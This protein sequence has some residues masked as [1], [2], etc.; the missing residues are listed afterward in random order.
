MYPDLM[1]RIFIFACTS[2]ALVAWMLIL[3]RGYG[4]LY[5]DDAYMFYRYAE[6]ARH[7]LGFSWNLDGVHTFG[8]TSL[9][10]ALV[11]LL[12][13]FLPLGPTQ[14]LLFASWITS[15][16]AIVCVSFA[17]IRN[18]RSNWLRDPALVTPVVALSLLSMKIF[19]IN[20]R[21]GMETMLAMALLA[22]CLH[23]VL[24]Q[25]RR[26][27]S[28]LTMGILVILTT[29]AR[30]EAALPVVLL[31]VLA[32]ALLPNVSLRWALRSLLVFACF[33]GL[34]LVLAR[35][36]FHSW[37]PLSFY[38]KSRGGY[39]GYSH[40]WYPVTAALSFL[41]SSWI[42]LVAIAVAARRSDWRLLV[43][44]L[45]PLLAVM[46]Y[47]CTITQIM[48]MSSRYDMPYLP[49]LVIPAA[50]IVD[51][52]MSAANFANAFS[53][54]T[55]VRSALFAAVVLALVFR[56]PKGL[57]RDLEQ[58]AERRVVSQGD[59]SFTTPALSPLQDVSYDDALLL[60]ASDIA[61]TLPEGA[62]M[63]ASEVGYLGANFPHVN[64]IDLAGLNDNEIARNG[65]SADAV[66]A[67]HPDLIWLPHN[68]YTWERGVL[69]TS[70]AFQADYEI[71]AGAL[72]FGVA[73][74]RKSP[75]RSRLE[76]G[77]AQVWRTEYPG[78]SPDRY[79]ATSVHWNR[80]SEA[81]S[82][83]PHP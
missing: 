67:H 40:R 75:Y 6:H 62:T 25:E 69:L 17:I 42:F 48:G 1:R 15:G 68:D 13:S 35:L 49:L 76:S 64:V 16:L 66:L 59:I 33:A 58:L 27:V 20:A 9:L 79:L 23:C 78:T 51:G 80:R 29:L 10:W 57:L 14:C 70:P 21:T 31:I 60:F 83:E 61:S 55:C 19:R 43:L 24:V 52:R 44:A 47:L 30:P 36:Y 39:F 56:F 50:L 28:P 32:A 12:F 53:A 11:V 18:A 81:P 38:L 63:A 34:T 4:Q 54:M 3:R 46:E 71:Y 65:F 77:L 8:M 45:V 22:M 26:S 7:G 74:A 5:F 72:K 41:R 2:A 73:I 82:V 37:L